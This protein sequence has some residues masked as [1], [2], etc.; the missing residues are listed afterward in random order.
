MQEKT[1]SSVLKVFQSLFSQKDIMMRYY[2]NFSIALRD[3]YL[4]QMPQ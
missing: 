1:F 4:N 2:S 3:L